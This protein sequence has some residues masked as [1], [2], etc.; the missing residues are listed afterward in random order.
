[1]TFGLQRVEGGLFVARR[2]PR[3]PSQVRIT[4]EH[5]L[6]GMSEKEV[7]AA[8]EL[9]RHTV[10]TYVKAIYRA[11]GVKSRAELLVRILSEDHSQRWRVG[12]LRDRQ[13]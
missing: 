10:H 9:S 12:E 4:L 6:T 7:A 5:L 11:F 1:M 13:S 3:L 2:A 8:M